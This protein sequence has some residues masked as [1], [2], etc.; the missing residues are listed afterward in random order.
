MSIEIDVLLESE[1]GKRQREF[2]VSTARDV[3][4]FT[5]KKEGRDVQNSEVSVLFTGDDFIADLNKQY[6]DENGPTD[7]L[8][9]P[10]LEFDSEIEE[11]NIPG[12]PDMLGDIVISLETA[13]RHADAHEK[14]LRQ[15]LALLLVHGTL[16]LLGYDHD[17][18][19]KEAV[20][21]ARQDEIL[22]ALNI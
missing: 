7:V 8:S 17:E 14:T 3:V 5:L 22:K 10:M 21:W 11:I 19:Q 15:E 9:F 18:P 2:L 12:L 1:I 4:R 6:R 16:H 13:S 20:M